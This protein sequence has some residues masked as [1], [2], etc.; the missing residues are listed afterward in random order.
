M[1]IYELRKQIYLLE[2]EK[3]RLNAVIASLHE[4]NEK[5]NG[6]IFDLQEQARVL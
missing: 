4:E 3:K 2:N 1:E 6:I 5:L